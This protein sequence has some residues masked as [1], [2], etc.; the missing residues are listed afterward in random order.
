MD[1][2]KIKKYLRAK[3]SPYMF[4]LETDERNQSALKELSQLQQKV[5]EQ[6]W[7]M[8]QTIAEAV[9][10]K[11]MAEMAEMM[12]AHMTDVKEYISR[13]IEKGLKDALIQRIIDELKGEKGDDGLDADEE[14]IVERILPTVISQIPPPIP[15]KTPIKGIDYFTS[16]EINDIELNVVDKAV[17]EVL[18]L[19]PPQKIVDLTPLQNE[20]KRVEAKIKEVVLPTYEEI[21]RGI[22][23]LELAKKLDYHS[24]LKNQPRQVSRASKTTKVGGGG[25]G[26]VQH[27][28]FTINAG[29]TTITTAYSIADAGNAIFKSAYQGGVLDKDV[30]F[31]VGSD[32]RTITFN[33][34]VQTQFENNTIFSIT[35]SRWNT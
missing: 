14:E 25:L 28:R 12:E 29:T 31:T 17:P 4:A 13:E 10:E 30:H 8:V 35:Y 11:R 24:G 32:Y 19:I 21:A 18:S 23:G 1:K 2:N 3:A 16:K 22:E 33:T 7:P 26:N 27:E 9:A 34:D 15:G 20:I 6:L 5:L